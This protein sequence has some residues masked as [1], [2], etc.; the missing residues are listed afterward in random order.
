M[1]VKEKS[2]CMKNIMEIIAIILGGVWAFYHFSATEFAGLEPNVVVD[3]DF[4]WG[5]AIENNY[6]YGV[7]KLQISN[8]ED[9]RSTFKIVES[10]LQVFEI[11]S[12][13]LKKNLFVDIKDITNGIPPIYNKT[14]QKCNVNDESCDTD[15]IGTYGPGKKRFEDFVFHFRRDDK[16]HKKIIIA[17]F[18]GK[19]YKI[20]YLSNN[21]KLS[22]IFEQLW[23]P[24][25]DL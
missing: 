8:A 25:C 6:C 22:P 12:D 1:N 17:I 4:K 11:D 23:T 3:T 19:P 16:G 2:E 9:S 15:F 5:K 13:E 14:F 24:K 7:L 10:K 21:T 18:T 20:N